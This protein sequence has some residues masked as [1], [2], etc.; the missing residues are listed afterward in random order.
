[1]ETLIARFRGLSLRQQ[2]GAGVGVA[3]A[4]LISFMV[5]QMALQEDQ[6]LLYAGLE[7]SAAGEVVAVLEGEGI[8]Y[9]IR[10]TS[11]YV[12]ASERD[13]LR[14]SLAQRNLPAAKAGG[15]ELL[16]E[17]DGFSTTSEMFSV[18]YWRAK[19]GEI[20]RTLMT[21]PGVE[22]ARV[23]I[24]V[25]ERSLFSRSEAERTASVT[26]TAPGGLSDGQVRAVRYLTALAIPGLP[27]SEVGVVETARGL[28]SDNNDP[29]SDGSDRHAATL[30]RSLLSLVEARV[31]VGNARVSVAM[32]RARQREEV[33]SR[34]VDPQG[35]AVLNRR[36][37]ESTTT[38][39]G[40]EQALTVAS[41]LPDGEDAA[42]ERSLDDQKSSE[43][44]AYA[45]STIERRVETL[46]GGIERLSVAILLNDLTVDGVTTP[47]PAEE[48][49][50]LRDVVS[51]AAGINPQRGDILT[52]RSLPFGLVPQGSSA[53]I[54]SPS[55]L[56]STG[57]MLGLGGL[58]A[59]GFFFFL[60]VIR[61]IMKA[62]KAEDFDQP[63][64][65]T[66]ILDA[67][68]GLLEGDPIQTLRDR[69]RE[70]PEAAASLLNAWLVDEEEA[71]RT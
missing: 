67:Q 6:A 9:A 13:R 48:M 69:A 52:I 50:A 64:D 63:I 34:T 33:E 58:L 1:M 66:L 11:L 27:A 43:E 14:L 31:G 24:G 57:T 60:F 10:G 7:P 42:S 26:L 17:L 56:P 55:A 41:D 44:I 30:E 40:T 35:S 2:I 49:E 3:A 54:E 20:A 47:R 18:T 29:L 19:E 68:T 71:Q 70:K 21:I 36:L 38:E 15:Y 5:I 53:P 37:T 8:D 51:A 16:D 12:P 23:H 46:P 32:E 25:G 62:P 28:L 45:V 65:G 59:V 39:S 22:N 4:A 61:P